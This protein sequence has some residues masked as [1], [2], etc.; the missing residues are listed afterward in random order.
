MMESIEGDDQGKRKGRC[1]GSNNPR[2]KKIDGTR[3]T[4]TSTTME[5]KKKEVRH[6]CG[7]IICSVGFVGG[8]RPKHETHTTATRSRV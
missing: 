6:H 1:D 5:P 3:E 8:V 7:V 2:P 4:G